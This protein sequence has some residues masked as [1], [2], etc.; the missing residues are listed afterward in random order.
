[1]ATLTWAD[2]KTLCR[3]YLGDSAGNIWPD[4]SL[5]VAVNDLIDDMTKEAKA[6]LRRNFIPLVKSQRAYDLPPDLYE[7]RGMRI[8]GKKTFGTVPE[9]LEEVD[10]QYLTA[11]GKSE[12]YYFDD[13]QTIAFWPVPTWTDDLTTF[14]SEFGCLTQWF[15]GTN[16]YAFNQEFGIVIDGIDD[17]SSVFFHITDYFG[18]IVEADANALVAEV[19]YVYQPPDIVLDSDLPDVPLNL[20]YALVYGVLWR[21]FMREGKG[22]N[23]MLAGFF[24]DRFE[25]QVKEWYSRNREISHGNDQMMSQEPVSFGSDLDWRM[26]VFP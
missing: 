6:T 3:L 19:T 12:W 18:E 14:T 13:P 17:A 4:S 23:P 26:R 16:N 24:R 2:I 11:T 20:E 1:M 22:K 5:L 21:C 9:K 10:S 8:N 25:E 15:D 7:V